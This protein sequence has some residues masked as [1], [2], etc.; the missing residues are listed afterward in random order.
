M[1]PD[2]AAES[3]I[4]SL[5]IS[6]PDELDIEAI[7]FDAGISI[8]Y[9]HLDGCAA[10]LVGFGNRAIATIKPCEVRG[11]ER[12]SIAHEIGHWDLHRGQSFQCRVFDLNENLGKNHSKERQADSYAAH[13]L[14]P[15]SLFNPI[16]GTYKNPGFGELGEVAAQFDTSL[17]ATSVRLVNVNKLPVIVAC[18][19]EGR[20]RWCLPAK[21]IPQ[22]WRLRSLLDEDSFAYDLW[23]SG[24]IRSKPSKQPAE[25]WFEN[26]DVDDFEILEHSVMS[27]KDIIVLLYLT[28]TEMFD[29]R[30][31]YKGRNVR[32]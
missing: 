27:G 7:A 1:S 18:F 6:S 9:R 32:R 11:R 25:I 3:R 15:T 28:S 26:E 29:D 21:D 22:H 5:G 13:L 10:T 23:K 2:I 30:F 17:L 8:E 12:F 14:M 19:T 4:A 31:E 16:I 24:T 20:R